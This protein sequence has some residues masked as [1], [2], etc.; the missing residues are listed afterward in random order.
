ME[1][2]AALNAHK[3]GAPGVGLR[4]GSVKGK[5]Q[6]EGLER[7]LE[8]GGKSNDQIRQLSGPQRYRAVKG[9]G[10]QQIKIGERDG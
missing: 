3:R 9:K 8:K 4:R 6:P 10:A 7:G 2:W 1:M 5:R